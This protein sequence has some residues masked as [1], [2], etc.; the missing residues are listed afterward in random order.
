LPFRIGSN[1]CGPWPLL[2]QRNPG[3]SLIMYFDAP[4]IYFQWWILK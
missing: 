2:L 1:V 4:Y 3:N